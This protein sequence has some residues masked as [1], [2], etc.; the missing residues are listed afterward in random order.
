MEPGAVIEVQ[1]YQNYD[2]N[3]NTLP[4]V[5]LQYYLSSDCNFDESDTYLSEAYSTINATINSEKEITTLA[6]PVNT[7]PGIYFILFKGDAIDVIN[8]IDEENN[9]VCKQINIQSSE[10]IKVYPNPTDGLI[11]FESYYSS[12]SKLEVYNN[13]GQMVSEF[14]KPGNTINIPIIPAVYIC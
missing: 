13:L 1:A 5:T 4:D 7:K 6:I 12:I 2:G 10:A 9:I 3:S 8:E 14:D 11:H